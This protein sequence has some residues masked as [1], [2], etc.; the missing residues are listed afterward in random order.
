MVFWTYLLAC[1]DGKLYCGYTN[2][3]ERRLKMHQL[4]RASRFTRVRLPVKLVYSEKFSSQRTAMRRE[5]E[6]KTFSRKKKLELI[7]NKE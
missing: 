5:A 4:G 3:M 7:K 6:I 1:S 2:N